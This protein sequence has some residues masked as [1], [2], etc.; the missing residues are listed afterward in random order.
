MNG[1]E[2]ITRAIEFKRPERLPMQYSEFGITDC[3]GFGLNYGMEWIKPYTE[4][5]DYWGC[6]WVRSEKENSGQCK[7]YPLKDWSDLDAYNFPDPDTEQYYQH[8]EGALNG[9]E[10][11]Y[12]FL[13]QFH[14]LFERLHFLRGFENVL[15]DLYINRDKLEFLVDKIVD[16]N[17]R[18]I[19][20]TAEIAKGRIDGFF[21]TDDWG[22]QNDTFIDPKLWNE[23]FKPKYKRIFDACK[24]VG[25][26]VWMHSCGKINKIIPGL[27]EAGVNVLNLLQP[28]T[29][30]IEEIGREFAGKV[31]FNTAGD[32]QHTLPFKGKEE[33]R[34]EARLLL[35]KWA[36][37]DG[38]FI[39]FDYVD[40]NA[41]G[42]PFEKRKWAF[43]AFCEFDPYKK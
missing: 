35:K 13:A 28:R 8:V 23:F 24:E 39:L 19:Q 38:G 20:N 5:K 41:I 21:F 7:G 3:V 29:L 31:C 22:T 1:K 26:H 12:I 15:M 30:G 32:I 18:I 40:G 9:N 36:T 2:L 6:V 25:W 34:E 14:L 11:K 33:I 42:V 4:F 37:K 43:E 17:V 10:D 16:F 27:I